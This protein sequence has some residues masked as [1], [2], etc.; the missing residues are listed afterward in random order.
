MAYT[1][2]SVVTNNVATLDDLPNDVGGLTAAQLKVLFDKFGADFV[3]W[4]NATHLVEADAHIANRAN[5]YFT[6]AFDAASGT[7]KI[8]LGWQPKI[9]RINACLSGGTK[10]SW[11][12]RVNGAAASSGIAFNGTSYLGI[13]QLVQLIHDVSNHQ[14]ANIQSFDADGFTL[15]WTMTGNPP[16]G[17]IEMSYEAEA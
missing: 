14:M 3:A 4:F 1:P 10:A 11:G 9:V 7:Q 5:A 17:L 16:S 2:C 8:T 13:G 15:V 6:R 12:V